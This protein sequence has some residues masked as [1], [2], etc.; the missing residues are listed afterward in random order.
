[1]ASKTS[2]W[3]YI[4]ETQKQKFYTGITT[5]IERRFSE[6]LSDPL[7]GAK[8]FRLDK[9]KIIVYR[10]QCADRASASVH[11]ASIK[12]MSRRKKELLIQN[13]H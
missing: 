11:E 7:K 13:K 6:H 9:P 2:W 10:K 8:F 12:K 4:I 5:D 1:M 3:V